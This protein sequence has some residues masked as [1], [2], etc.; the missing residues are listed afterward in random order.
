MWLFFNGQIWVL[1]VFFRLWGDNLKFGKAVNLPLFLV[2]F[3]FSYFSLI[4]S[5]SAA[6]F[7]LI[8]ENEEREREARRERGGPKE[9]FFSLS[10]PFCASTVTE[11]GKDREDVELERSL[12]ALPT[13]GGWRDGCRLSSRW[14]FSLHIFTVYNLMLVIKKSINRTPHL[15]SPAQYVVVVKRSVAQ[16]KSLRSLVCVRVLIFT[17]IEAKVFK[18]RPTLPPSFL[19]F[20]TFFHPNLHFAP[21][22]DHSINVES[23]SLS[24]W[25]TPEFRIP[26]LTL[27]LN[28][29]S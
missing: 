10:G 29:Q 27:N 15:P 19:F 17:Q 26:L 22:A 25:W 12:A 8:G 5:T 21:T 9:I 23:L 11:I 2:L 13:G 24:I 14:T 18:V 7:V 16:R 4:S 1:N 28:P 20:C 3:I 6:S